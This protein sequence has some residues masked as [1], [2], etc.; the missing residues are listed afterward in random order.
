MLSVKCLI[1][2]TDNPFFVLD[3][4]EVEHVHFKRVGF[5]TKYF[6]MTFI[7]YDHNIPPRTITAIEMKSYEMIQEWPTVRGF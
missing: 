5:A 3:L 1:N 6:D 7:F 4:S 2:I